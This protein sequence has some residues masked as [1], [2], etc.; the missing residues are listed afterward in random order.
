MFIVEEIWNHI[1]SFL[2]HNIN[3]HG[4]HLQ[5]D[6]YIK[7]HNIVVN[8]LPKFRPFDRGSGPY[9]IYSSSTK[10][11]RFVKF[12]YTLKYKRIRQLIMT[13]M[14]YKPV[15]GI[16]HGAQH[17]IIYREYFNYP[18]KMIKQL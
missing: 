13:Y 7:T 9:I 17:E 3:V 14:F 12:V 4:K 18:K 2:I 16:G 15:F 5:N 10:K 8:N 6:P 11:Y 1:K